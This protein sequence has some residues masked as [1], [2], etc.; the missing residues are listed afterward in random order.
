M[1][2]IPYNFNI[3]Y[4]STNLILILLYTGISVNIFYMLYEIS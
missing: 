3:L 4:N 2:I 1:I